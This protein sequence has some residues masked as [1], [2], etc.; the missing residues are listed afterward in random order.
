M[1]FDT[2][3]T[4]AK[5]QVLTWPP[6]YTLRQCKRSKNVHFK[7]S[8]E[9]G[10]EIIVP[11]RFQRLHILD[12]LEE[13]RTWIQKNLPKCFDPNIAVAQHHI[14]RTIHLLALDEYWHIIYRQDNTKSLSVKQLSNN[15]LQIK[16]P[17][18]QPSEIHVLLR[19]WL[20]MYAKDKLGLWIEHLAWLTKLHF[21][22][23]HIRGQKTMWGS[24]NAQKHISLNYKLLFLPCRLT[25][26]V[27][28]H[29]LCH[30]RH[31]D[32]SQQFWALLTHFDH[33]TPHHRKQLKTG[34]QYVPHWL[35]FLHG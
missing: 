35:R 14:P 5:A 32:H 4:A 13:Q 24:C 28:L 19:R 25:R 16:G 6:P 30:L 10:L 29:E 18:F 7:I 11:V 20:K 26:H 15:V 2:Q 33:D 1:H 17:C 31:L 8:P 9:K 12:L 23:L 3:S 22:K 21:N 27:L 34:D